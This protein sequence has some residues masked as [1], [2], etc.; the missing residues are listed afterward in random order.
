MEEVD[1]EL[2]ELLY[3]QLYLSGIIQNVFSEFWM[4]VGGGL[5]S[6]IS[7]YGIALFSW[8]WA[9]TLEICQ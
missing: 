1:T 5:A 8:V 9:A 4:C 6:Q 3:H 7:I 2:W